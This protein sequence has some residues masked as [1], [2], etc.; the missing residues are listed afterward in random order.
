M[1][2]SETTSP[3]V[4]IESVM[5]SC[6]IDAMEGRDVATVD[7]PGAFMQTEQ[8]GTVHVRLE[9]VMVKQLL[10]IDRDKYEKY[11]RWH[12][13]KPILYVR[14]K[15]ALYGTLQAAMLFWKDL[16]SKLQEWGFSINPY[17]WCVANKLINGKQCTVLWHV[18]DLK[19]SHVDGDV[20]SDIINKLDKEYGKVTPLTITRGKVHEY[21]GMT[22]DFNKPRKV[23]IIMLKYVEELLNEMPDSMQ[24]K[25]VTPAAQHLFQTNNNSSL[26]EADE[27]EFFH[28]TTAKLLFLSKRARPDLQTAISFLCTRVQAPDLDDYKK[29]A[30]VIRY[31]RATKEIPLTLEGDSINILKWYVGSSFA[32][33]NDM[34]GHTGAYF[35]LGKGGVISSS[36]RTKLSDTVK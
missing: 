4:A 28:T 2:K 10:K 9:G 30:R 18:D 20:V 7:I 32:I 21:L 14:L 13:N 27:K 19:I 29:L 22:I 5:I 16:S 24:G 8:E 31:L 33:H 12:N 23:Q 35:T 15:K 34:K 25:A 17:D 26:L 11:I 6:T 36:A 1:T 3:T